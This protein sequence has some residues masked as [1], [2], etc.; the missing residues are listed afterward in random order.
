[1]LSFGCE[2]SEIPDIISTGF[3]NEEHH[4]QCSTDVMTFNCTSSSS[5]YCPYID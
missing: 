5:A 4:E 1:M 2:L 3:D